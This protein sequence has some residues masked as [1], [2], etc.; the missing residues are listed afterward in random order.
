MF[1]HDLSVLKK[2]SCH[3]LIPDPR[4]INVKQKALSESVVFIVTT[5]SV[6]NMQILTSICWFQVA[7]PYVAFALEAVWDVASESRHGGGMATSLR[8]G[9]HTS[10]YCIQCT[11]MFNNNCEGR[12][13]A[14]VVRS[15]W[16]ITW[17]LYQVDSVWNG[18]HPAPW[19]NLLRNSESDY[20]VIKKINYTCEL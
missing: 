4:I 6:L 14:R 12:L 5:R 16:F 20:K 15:S 19:A 1:F 8:W 7:V 17:K 9:R 2:Y 3:D 18:N 13:L 11:E 10:A